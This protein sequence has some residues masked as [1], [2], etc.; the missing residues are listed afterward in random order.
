MFARAMIA[1]LLAGSITPITQA[2]DWPQ[3]RGPNGSGVSTEKE[4]PSEWNSEQ[5]LKWKTPIPGV[6]WSAPIVVGDKI[7]V[8]TAVTDKQNKPKPGGGFGSGGTKGGGFKGGP[9]GGFGGKR[10]APMVTY[11]FEVLCLDRNTGKQLWSQTA[12]EGKPTIPTH[13]SNTYATETPVTDGKNV[14]AYF[15]MHG[16]YCYDLDGELVWKKDLG[17]FPM[18]AG[19]GTASSPVLDGDRLFIQCDN[20]E[21]SFLIALDKTTGKELWKEARGERSSWATP[22]VWKNKDRTE[23]V[24]SG[25]KVRSYDPVTGK[26]LWE[27]NM[28]GQA[29]SSPVGTNEF[30]YVGSGQG[31]GGNESGGGAPFAVKAEASGDVTPEN[32]K[33]S[34]AGVAWVQ[35]RGGPEMASPLVYQDCVYIFARNGGLVSC[36]EAKTGTPAYT[37]ERITGARAFWSSP[38]AHDGKIYCVDEDGQTFVL[39]AGA[40]FK[41]LGKNS[42]KEMFWSTPAIAGDAIL[43]RGVDNLYCIRK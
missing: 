11:K 31:R 41:L 35:S 1:G 36:Y 26:Q 33:T 30:L 3:F 38:W 21:K 20:E 39:Q 17:T 22:L 14:F 13:G 16:L 27:L 23:I 40:E 25:R 6:G 37:K 32:G 8:T 10:A 24:A 12:L 18:V 9:G 5:N 15:G 2:A 7:F 42:L 4:L 19:W 43:L 34:S 28:G 29:S